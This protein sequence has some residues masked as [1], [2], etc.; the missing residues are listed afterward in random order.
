MQ[1]LR[2]T[3]EISYDV[4]IYSLI[5]L[6]YWK[7]HIINACVAEDSLIILTTLTTHECLHQSLFIEH[8]SSLVM[9]ESSSNL[10]YKHKY[11]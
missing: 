10:L 9:A 2:T 6:I 7:V 8:R 3:N 11:L 5:Q 1:Y 4:C